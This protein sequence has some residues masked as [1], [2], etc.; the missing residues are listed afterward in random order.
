M[1]ARAA[2]QRV[3]AD[4]RGASDGRSQLN[5]LLGASGS[6]CGLFQ[7]RPGCRSPSTLFGDMPLDQ[8]CKDTSLGEPCTDFAEARD[9]VTRGDS[10]AAILALRRVLSQPALPSRHYAQAWHFL[11]G[12]GVHP[13]PTEARTILGVVVKVG[14]PEGLDLLAAYGDLS[15]QYYN[16]SGAGV[17]WE[18]PDASR[19]LYPARARHRRLHCRGHWPVE[20]RETLGPFTGTGPPQSAHPCRPDVWRGKAGCP[21]RR[22]HGGA[23]LLGRH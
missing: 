19:Q 12:L 3:A 4:E 11:R 16:H 10:A 8:W 22:Q 14:L 5:A 2:Q 18:H 7:R 23:P 17:V 1:S 9:Q 6:V 21:G 13:H 20:G 15:A